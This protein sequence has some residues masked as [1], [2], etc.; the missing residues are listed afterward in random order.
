MRKSKE[1]MPRYKIAQNEQYFDSLI[2]LLQYDPEVAHK[3]RDIIMNLATQPFL[4]S[5]VSKL[6][7]TSQD[8]KVMDNQDEPASPSKF[9]WSSIFDSDN[10][11]KLLYTLEIISAILV[12]YSDSEKTREEIIASMVMWLQRFLELRGLQEL[13]R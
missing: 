5:V 7:F 12:G 8:G 10:V 13:Q 6:E 2:D 3:A 1:D 11:N 4:Y 9:D